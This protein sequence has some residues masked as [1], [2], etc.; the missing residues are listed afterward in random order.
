MTEV[1]TSV[2]T[3]QIKGPENRNNAAIAQQ[4][5]LSLT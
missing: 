4:E 5:R 1:M 3:M 2:M